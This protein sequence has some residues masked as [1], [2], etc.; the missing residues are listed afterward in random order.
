MTQE[1][2]GGQLPAF[3]TDPR[4]MLKRRWPWLI[5]VFALGAVATAVYVS[6][7]PVTYL[8]SATLVINDQRIPD[9]FV[10]N[11]V[12]DDPL[13]QLDAL[14]G[15]ILSS[16][17]LAPLIEEH[18]LYPDKRK[19]TPMLDLV[20]LARGNVIVAPAPAVPG[21]RRAIGNVFMIQFRDENPAKAAAMANALASRFTRAAGEM[22]GETTLLTT[23]FMTAE[24]KRSEL[25]LREQERLVSEFKER[26]RGEL[27]SEL[28][29][30]TAK[31]ERLS[32]LR[33][34]LTAQLESAEVRLED[35]EKLGDLANPSSPYARLTSL[36]SKLVSELAVNTEEHPNVIAVKRQIE[37]L[38]KEIGSGATASGDPNHEVALR[39]ARM[40]VD[41]LRAQ[42]ARAAAETAQLEE[43][44]SRTPMREEELQALTQKIAVLQDTYTANLRKLQQ[45]ELSA[46]VE[47]A[48][49]GSRVEV[50]DLAAPPS[51]PESTRLKY[52]V[53]GLFVSVV[54]ALGVAVLFEMIDPVIV[55]ADQLESELGLTVL[56]SIGRIG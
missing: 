45:A 47:S 56:G 2:E 37:A 14:I 42:I 31:L 44:V 38:E 28:G 54:G 11:I 50:L 34:T 29:P 20:G 32:V 21:R 26:Y 55:S 46:S 25:A 36:R 10:Q 30:N 35:L 8:A 43:R 16:E 33:A 13:Q 15:E 5:A 41:D 39:N 7:V 40:Q 19:T 1:D 48:Q 23:N 51:A 4:G 27:P 17:R 12:T 53:A 18:Q 49:R 9:Q 6:Q 52:L 3:L 22:T 24:L